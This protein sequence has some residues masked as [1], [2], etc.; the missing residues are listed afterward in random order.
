MAV[1]LTATFDAT[2]SRVALASTGW[3]GSDLAVQYLVRKT[4]AATWQTV[5]GAGAVPVSGGITLTQYDYEFPWSGTTT[6]TVDYAVYSAA[7]NTWSYALATTVSI[8]ATAWLKICGYP[9]LNVKVNPVG[10]GD[11][12][13][14]GRNSLIEIIGSSRPTGALDVMGG[15]STSVVIPTIAWAESQAL[16]TRLAVG[17][18]VLLHSDEE[19]LGLPTMYAVVDRM[20]I[21]FTD[22][23]HSTA[24][25]ITLDLLEV[26]KPHWAYAGAVGTYQ[27]VLNAHA[28]YTAVLAT[29]PTYLDLAQIVG[30][31]ADV[32][33]P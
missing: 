28:T 17:G 30:S 24:R 13:R 31:P 21:A 10:A 6:G 33:V 22:Q 5:R 29:Y 3:S 20:R 25:R 26:T 14:R 2:R 11:V 4:G 1:V 15:R 16:D 7:T 8:T 27:S 9:S 23:H 12:E 18:V 19:D 32:V